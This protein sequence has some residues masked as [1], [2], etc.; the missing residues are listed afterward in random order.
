MSLIALFFLRLYFLPSM[1]LMHL[2]GGPED[3]LDPDSCIFN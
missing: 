3:I 2:R 1:E